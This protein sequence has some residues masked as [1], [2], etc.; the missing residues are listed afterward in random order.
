MTDPRVQQDRD[1][2]SS[3]YAETAVGAEQVFVPSSH[4]RVLDNEKKA[5]VI[6]ETYRLLAIGVFS[7]MATAWLASR[8]VSLVMMLCTPIGFL[9]A[10]LGLNMVPAMALSA[11]RNSRRGAALTLALDGALSGVCISPLIFQAMLMSGTGTNAPN[12]VQSA[13]VVT[14]AVFLGI[15]GYIYQ[16]GT[17]FNYGKGFGVGLAWTLLIGIPINVF[18]L[19]SGTFGLM[20]C[21]GVGVLGTLQLLWATSRVLHDPEFDDPA[22][23]ALCLFAGLFN[24]FTTILRLF[25]SSRR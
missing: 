17:Q 7:S 5:E 14:A 25:M 3:G 20:L 18:W 1:Y 9:L 10:F 15:S 21:L 19:G 4:M 6:R 12:L 11:A 23:G 22:Y 16:S 8:S 2:V 13:L 24:L